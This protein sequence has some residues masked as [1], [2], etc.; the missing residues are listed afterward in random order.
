MQE[1]I[2]S[3]KKLLVEIAGDASEDFALKRNIS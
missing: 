1:E 3:K 2:W